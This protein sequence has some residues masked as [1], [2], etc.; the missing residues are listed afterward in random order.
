MSR[1]AH[2][3]DER[4]SFLRMLFSPA[5]PLYP[6]PLTDLNPSLA[7]CGDLPSPRPPAIPRLLRPSAYRAKQQKLVMIGI[8][9]VLVLLILLILYNKLFG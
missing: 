4:P 2:G 3:S 5:P 8:I 7:G 1:R 9:V 6:S